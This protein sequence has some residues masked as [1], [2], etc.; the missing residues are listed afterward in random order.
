MNTGRGRDMGL[1]VNEQW[2]FGHL[3]STEFS[4]RLGRSLLEEVVQIPFLAQVLQK[5][6]RDHRHKKCVSG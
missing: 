4:F 6:L 2:V 5:D 3:K 1:G